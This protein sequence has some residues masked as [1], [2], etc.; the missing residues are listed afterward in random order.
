MPT[1]DGDPNPPHRHTIVRGLDRGERI[2]QCLFVSCREDAHSEALEPP[3]QG[4]VCYLFVRACGLQSLFKF[5][6][7]SR[8]QNII[9]LALVFD[10]TDSLGNQLFGVNEFSDRSKQ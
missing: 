10:S 1:S 8:D 4:D 7:K 2:G 6:P 3:W 5:S 9:S